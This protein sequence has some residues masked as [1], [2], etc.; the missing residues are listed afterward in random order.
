MNRGQKAFAV[1]GSASGMGAAVKGRLE[2]TGARVIGV[3]THDCDVEADLRSEGGRR[4][5]VESVTELAGGAL[6]GAVACAGLGPHVVP[7]S[8]IVRVNYFGAIS[9][10]EG[11]LPALQKGESPAAVAIASNS[12]SLT[13]KHD[14]LLER[15][16]D[17]DEAGA[18]SLAD[19][20]GGVTSY[21][22]SK[23]ALT[24]RLRRISADWG[25]CGV[26]LNAVAPG[27][28]DT[29]MLAGI[30]SDEALRPLVEG[31]PI[32]LGRNG[33]AE[34]VAA[35]VSFLLDPACRYVHGSVL[36]VDGGSDA[37]IRPDSV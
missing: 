36:F 13:P 8:D 33:S 29:P 22:M 9:F 15:L 21:G 26:R 17:D 4:L 32:P 23:L 14:G 34:E 28:I 37:L 16:A 7:A 18:A 3:D 19:K 27:P 11:L 20:V 35:A 6:D 2:E 24:R 10:L 25:R 12:A 31:L 1:S 5:A 30:L